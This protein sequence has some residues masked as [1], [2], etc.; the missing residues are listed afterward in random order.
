MALNSKFAQA[1]KAR[2]DAL[3]PPEPV[4][5]PGLENIDQAMLPDVRNRNWGPPL[6]AA[7]PVE[8]DVPGV[9][10]TTGQLTD[11]VGLSLEEARKLIEEPW[12]YDEP[13]LVSAKAS[14]IQT[15]LSTGVKVDDTNLRRRQTDMLPKLLEII[16]R[17]E[18]RL[19]MKVLE[20]AL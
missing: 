7:P 19:P 15:V 20:Q 12:M 3:V 2:L 10:E 1:A 14:M 16:A 18:K 8:P 5:I 9:I 6:P 17:E 13:R 11:L 4:T